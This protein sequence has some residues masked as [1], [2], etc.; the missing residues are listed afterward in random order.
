[1]NLLI[2]QKFRFYSFLSMFLLV[3]VHGYNL[4]DTYLQP[5]SVV[6][7][8]MTLTTF[9][10]FFTANGLFRFRIPMLFIISGY[11][12]ALH[13]DNPYKERTLKR[14]RTLGI[15]YLFWSAVGILLTYALEYNDLFLNAIKASGLAYADNNIATVH[16]YTAEDW[17]VRWAIFP[18]SFQLWFIRVLL[19]YNIAYPVLRWLVTRYPIVWLSV[20]GIL[21]FINFNLVLV[22]GAGLFFFSWGIWIQKNNF[23]LEKTPKNLNPTF[24]LVAFVVICFLKT[25]LAFLHTENS[26]IPLPL[27]VGILHRIAEVA[28]MIGLWY[29]GNKIIAWLSAQSFFRFLMSYS[30]MIYVTHVPILYY[31]MQIAN[32]YLIDYQ[33]HRLL[34]YIFVPLLLSLYAVLV[35]SFLKKVAPTPYQWFTGGR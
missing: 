16:Q 20:T 1:M 25:Y 28:G 23:D 26:P 33:Y 7:E 4:Q 29:S 2:S 15:P 22:E 9:F 5:W 35:G 13:D 10:E 18:I 12:Y 21:W 19:F 6:Q 34:T 14:L 11:L 30:F 27:V 31:I 17:L 3:Y 32:Q 8:P 24:V